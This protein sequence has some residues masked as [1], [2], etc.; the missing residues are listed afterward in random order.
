MESRADQILHELH[1]AD[2]LP[3]AVERICSTALQ[4][5]PPDQISAL[6]SSL[7]QQAT[8]AEN[9][10]SLCAKIH[11]CCCCAWEAWLENCRQKGALDTYVYESQLPQVCVLFH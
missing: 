3:S 4:D 1:Q 7:R 9:D 6:A 2:F 10:K 5:L 8:A 11:L